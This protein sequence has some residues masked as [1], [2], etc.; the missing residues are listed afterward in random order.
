[1]NVWREFQNNPCGRRVGDC[2]VR[3]LSVALD[4]S[5]EEAFD[6]LADSAFKMCDM[7]SSNSVLGAVLRQHGFYR[8]SISPDCGD[9]YTAEDFAMEHPEGIYVLGFG[10]HVATIVDGYIYDA[11]DSSQEIPQYV[12]YLPKER[13]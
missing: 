10:T 11:W 3:A 1:M 6:L 7:P 12:W 8:T 5:W 2:T 13:V 4:I 9:C